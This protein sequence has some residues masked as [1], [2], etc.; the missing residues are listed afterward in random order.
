MHGAPAQGLYRPEHEHDSCGVA[1]V[2]D[3]A[4]RRS[5]DVVRQ[6]RAAL[7]RLDHRGARGAEP[8]TGDGAGVT[9]QVPDEFLRAVVDFD[10]PPAGSYAT[11]LVFLPTDAVD[12]HRAVRILEKY[13]RTEGAEVIGWRDVPTVAGRTGADRAGR[14]APDPSGLPVAARSS[15]SAEPSASATL[16]G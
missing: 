7:C 11:G 6:G 12:D 1:F 10:L 8:D 15:G 9:I 13:A 16:R 5:H 2:V 4:G 3:V 14:D